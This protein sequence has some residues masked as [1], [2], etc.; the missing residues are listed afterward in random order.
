[1]SKSSSRNLYPINASREYKTGNK[2]EIE[3]ARQIHQQNE[4]F[5][6][7][8]SREEK[9]KFQ[10]LFQLT[11]M[12]N[13]FYTTGKR[14]EKNSKLKNIKMQEIKELINWFESSQRFDVFSQYEPVTGWVTN[15]NLKQNVILRNAFAKALFETGE[16]MQRLTMNDTPLT[17]SQ[18][19]LI[20]STQQNSTAAVVLSEPDPETGEQFNLNC[21]F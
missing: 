1:M 2:D 5:T 4:I 17:Q 12:F 15:L 16:A 3:N 14:L 21:K 11:T 20:L 7:Q 9:A 8:L 13:A 6:R 18:A 10:K 19:P